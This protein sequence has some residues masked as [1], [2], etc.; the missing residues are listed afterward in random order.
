MIRRACKEWVLGRHDVRGATDERQKNHLI[1][2]IKA[3]DRPR[4][5]A[6]GN[7]C[8][9]MGVRATSRRGYFDLRR[10]LHH[11]SGLLV[12]CSGGHESRPHET[13]GNPIESRD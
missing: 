10:N 11:A 3:L 5:V 4:S 8:V 2:V 7:A 13:G 1:I 6:N 12:T 9:V